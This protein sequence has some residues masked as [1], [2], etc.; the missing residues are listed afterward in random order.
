M[1]TLETVI[2]LF[3][4]AGR[5][6]GSINVSLCSRILP[7]RGMIFSSFRGLSVWEL[8]QVGNS[9]CGPESQLWWFRPDF[10]SLELQSFPIYFISG[11]SSSISQQQRALQVG[12][13]WLLLRLS[14][15][16]ITM[17]II[18]LARKCWPDSCHFKI[19]LAPLNSESCFW[20]QLPP[21]SPGE[22]NSHHIA[23]QKCR[24]SP[25]SSASVNWVSYRSC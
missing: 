3:R 19:S 16:M 20:K 2:A 1:D 24:H 13:F 11:T 25:H 5:K 10:C 18:L 22:E 4:K 12:L 7:Q 17:P 21:I 23:I 8:V 14:W 6:I 9:L 15:I